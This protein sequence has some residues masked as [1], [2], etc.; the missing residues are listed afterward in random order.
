[1]KSILKIYISDPVFQI[2]LLLVSQ[3]SQIFLS[4]P[5][6]LL[7][8]PAGIIRDVV[9]MWMCGFADFCELH[10]FNFVKK[11]SITKSKIFHRFYKFDHLIATNGTLNGTFYHTYLILFFQLILIPI[12]S[13]VLFCFCKKTEICCSICKCNLFADL[14][15]RTLLVYI[16]ALCNITWVF[17]EFK[18]SWLTAKATGFEVLLQVEISFMINE[19]VVD[20]LL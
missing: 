19:R 6:F 13:I 2:F 17:P 14:I 7:T 16:F 9:F 4:I 5:S 1:M 11:E 10:G 15:V 12:V 8:E 20:Y 3:I 18:I